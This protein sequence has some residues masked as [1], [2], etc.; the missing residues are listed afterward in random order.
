LT[1]RA[2]RWFGA[3]KSLVVD[4]ETGET[5]T[6]ARILPGERATVKR[7]E[8][9]GR[10]FPV[11]DEI[12]EASPHRAPANC[13]YYQEC[14]GCDLLHV[15]EAEEQ[16]YKALTAS[17]V[18]ERF[19]GVVPKH[20]ETVGRAHRGAHRAR[21]RFALR[22]SNGAITLGLRALSGELVDIVDC[23]ASVPAVRSIMTAVRKI[24]RELPG[25]EL[26][27]VEVSAGVEGAAVVFDV[28]EWDPE[29]GGELINAMQ[30]TP[31]VS[32]TAIRRGKEKI[33]LL[34][35]QWPRQLPVGDIELGPAPDAW[36]Q[37]TPDRAAELY[38]WVLGLGLHH[39]KTVLD[40]TCGTGGLTL[41]L[42]TLAKS[43]LGVDAN[44]QALRSAMKS[45]QS[46]GL[47]NTE[48]RGGKIETVAKRMRDDRGG[49]DLV[50]VNPMRRSLGLDCMKDLAALTDEHLLYLAPAPRAGAEDIRDLLAEGFQIARVAAV[51]LHPGTSKSLMAVLLKKT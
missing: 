38:A 1:V 6:V 10:R 18:L 45:S 2:L 5:F 23:P 27:G 32:A 43:V 4:E 49:F 17:E 29:R 15:T 42:A 11:A 20:V 16:S 14:S 25:L 36:T 46:L 51:N 30:S 50:I 19:A 31:G 48:F 35:G 47:L 3:G 33:E 22:R 26:L 41:A 8:R 9:A 34:A 37:P 13:S 44:W 40:A 12:L 7:F 28:D 39:G 24:V 21:A